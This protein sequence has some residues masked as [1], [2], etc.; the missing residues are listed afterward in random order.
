MNTQILLAATLAA[1]TLL[2]AVPPALAE[3]K[4]MRIAPLTDLRV[5]DPIFT[6]AYAVRTHA[7][8]VYDVPLALDSK[9]VPRPQMVDS[10]VKSADGRQWTFKLRESLRF[11]DGAPVTANDMVVS[12]QRW[13]KRDILGQAMVKA[14]GVF[15]AQGEQSFTLTLT[16]PFGLVLE[17][18]SRSAFVMPARVAQADLTKPITDTTGSGP[19][20]FKKDE[21]VPGNKIVWVKN[22]NYV[23]RKEA[24]DGLAGGKKVYLDRVE[25][26]VMPDPNT[27]AQA[28]RRGEIDMIEGVG[29]DFIAPMMGEKDLRVVA[30]APFHGMMYLNQLHPPFNNPKARQAMLHLVKQADLMAGLGYPVNL[31][32]P[33]CGALF[34]CGTANATEAGSEPYRTQD[35]AKAKQLLAE[36]GY[37]GEKIVVLVPTGVPVL[38]PLTQVAIKQMQAA[39]LNIDGQV[40]DFGSMVARRTRKDAP[41]K[42]GWNI[43]ISAVAQPDLET[44]VSNGFLTGGCNMDLPGWPCDPAL[45]QLVAD[46][47][48]E[49]HAAERRKL[50][51]TIQ[52]RAYEVVSY[53]PLGQFTPVIGLRKALKGTTVMEQTGFPAMWG[54][55]K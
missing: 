34:V 44:P 41:D 13:A 22:P 9:G 31:R 23:P 40:M 3:T 4:V 10:W 47:A 30:M 36:A 54:V 14:G 8:M 39:G 2:A 21:W 15:K 5:L 18:L 16:Q 51:E 43:Y 26:T 25:W 52:R 11:H 20:I 50:V 6:G 48:R 27:Q 17:A 29:A 1:A 55:D 19:F 33:Y 35:I 37:K 32:M 49:P 28:I 53:V 24:A 12:L 38:G 45:Q 46:W 7:Y 42:G